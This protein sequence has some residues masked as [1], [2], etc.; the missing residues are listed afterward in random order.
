MIAFAL[1]MIREAAITEADAVWA[2]KKAR[3]YL[4][5]HHGTLDVPLGNV[6]RLIRGEH[7]YPVDGLREVL[8][9]ADSKQAKH[10]KG[11]YAVSG[12]DCFIQI[13]EF[14]PD[15]PEIKTINAFGAQTTKAHCRPNGA[16]YAAWMEENV[17][18]QGN[19]PPKCRTGLSSITKSCKGF[20]LK[21]SAK[22]F[23]P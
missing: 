1:L 4:L 10:H 18:R 22:A 14:G 11:Q 3:K 19:D 6:Q 13:T 8:R 9:A 17:L 23:H 21:T 7:S 20:T 12:G 15:G 5:R 2:I 16:L